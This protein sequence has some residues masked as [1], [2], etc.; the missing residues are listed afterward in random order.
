MTTMLQELKTDREKA[1]RAFLMI[2]LVFSVFCIVFLNS[3]YDSLSRYPY[4]DPQSRKQIKDH[5]NKEEIEYIIEYS[6]AP[7]MFVSF[8]NSPGFNIYHAQAYKQLS[9]YAWQETPDQIVKMIEETYEDMSVEELIAYLDAY[10]YDEI[11]YFLEHGDGYAPG[12]RLIVDANAIDTYVNPTRSVSVRVPKNLLQISSTIVGER[13]LYLS[14][15]AHQAL[16][17]L[18]SA[19]N[20]EYRMAQGCGGLTIEKAYVSYHDQE[21]LFFNKGSEEVGYPGHNEHQLGLAVDFGIEGITD[22]QLEKTEQGI[23]LRD[24]AWRFGFVQ[25][26]TEDVQ[27]LTNIKPKIGHYRYVGEELA[28]MLNESGMRFARYAQNKIE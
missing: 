25:T 23:W 2:L 21:Q 5:L 3:R 6:I 12:T 13:E 27:D 8:L 28:R 18:C 17:G 4:R 22:A 15:D 7:N 10:S 1:R 9:E 19:L 24:N 20:A 26:Y 14:E 11:H 16:N